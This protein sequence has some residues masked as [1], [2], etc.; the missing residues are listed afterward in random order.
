MLTATTNNKLHRAL[1]EKRPQY[2]KKH[3]K[4]IFL[5]DNAPSHTSTIVQNYLET[6][7]W[8]VPHTHPRLFTRPGTFW[9]SPV[10]ADGPRA[11]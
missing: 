5:H 10:F 3:D 6:L 8:E 11:R 9:L 2:R 1:H 7:N 4:L